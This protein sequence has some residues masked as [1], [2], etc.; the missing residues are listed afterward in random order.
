MKQLALFLA[1][2]MPFS[3][4]PHVRSNTASVQLTLI[5]PE[6]QSLQAALADPAQ[7]PGPFNPWVVTVSYNLKQ[8]PSSVSIY[9]QGEKYM[10]SCGEQACPAL[11]AQQTLK[12]TVP[13]IPGEKQEFTLEII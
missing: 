7:A 4:A 10:P 8:P 3:A 11:V 9:Y 1:L 12:F 13:F 2:L 6:T 5:V